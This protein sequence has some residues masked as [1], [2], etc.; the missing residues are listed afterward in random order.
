[1]NVGHAVPFSHPRAS[2]EKAIWP[3]TGSGGSEPP[4]CASVSVHHAMSS[5]TITVAIFMIII[6]SSLLS[7]MPRVFRHQKYIV[8]RIAM[9]AAV[10]A[11]GT[12]IRTS[13]RWSTSFTSP[14]M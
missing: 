1:V 11:T 9:S 3:W 14:A 2:S 6:A 10:A 8:T 13:P 7:W 5:T 12:C 4:R